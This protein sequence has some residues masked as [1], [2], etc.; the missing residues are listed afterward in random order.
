MVGAGAEVGV[1]G[2]LGTAGVLGELGVDGADGLDDDA[3]PDASARNITAT[4]ETPSRAAPELPARE[5][6][7]APF[8]LVHPGGACAPPCPL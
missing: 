3:Q 2:L 1:L 6:T 8:I 4:A 7:A 5:F